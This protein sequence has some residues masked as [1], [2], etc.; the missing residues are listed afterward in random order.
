M[1]VG[2]FQ[3]IYLRYI[4][5]PP[6]DKHIDYFYYLEG[7]MPHRR[8]KILPA[9]WLDLEIN[10]GG[11][12]SVYDA[13]DTKSV[14][15]CVDSWW[16]G[17]WSTYGTVAWPTNIQLLGIHFKP[18]GAYPFLKFPLSELHNQIVSAD[19]IWGTS[20][21][22]L[23]EQLYAAPTIHEK[24]ALLERLLLARHCEVPY[25]LYAVHHG[26]REILRHRG[27]LSI[28]VLS[29]QM[30]ISHN[31]LL[32]QFKRMVGI[33]PKA[34]ARLYRLKYALHS[35]DPMQPVDWA[36]LANQSHYYD[37]SHFN[38]D[39]RAFTGHTPTEYLRLR[40]QAY[41]TNPERDQLLHVLSIE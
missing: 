30:G 23:H 3:L 4:P 15:T 7:A 33:S 5:S 41:I 22:E 36:L 17:V 40:R 38:N 21:A 29:D 28:Q 32:G 11:A 6:L 27:A 19:A 9:G 14:A 34:L 39:F 37:Q 20:V 12:I 18:G 25:G 2:N 8:E 24:F 16:A 35:I 26:V 31:Y 10:F 1:K 13:S